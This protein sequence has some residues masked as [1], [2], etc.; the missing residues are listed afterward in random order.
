MEKTT[1]AFLESDLP[2]LDPFIMREDTATGWRGLT[3]H[4]E[5]MEAK[6]PPGR[7]RPIAPTGSVMVMAGGKPV[8]RRAMPPDNAT[9]AP[10]T[11]QTYL[12]HYDRA[13]DLFKQC[14]TL[15]AKAEIDYAA[16]MAVTTRTRFLRALILLTL[17]YWKAGLLDLESRLDLTFPEACKRVEADGV[18]RWRGETLRGKSLILVQDAGFGDTIMGLRYVAELRASFGADVYLLA[19]MAFATLAGRLVPTIAEHGRHF[20]FYCPTLSLMHMMG[21][22]PRTISPKPYLA[23]S[24]DLV[25]RLR[26]L[27]RPKTRR[28]IGIAW[29][30]GNVVPGD[31]HREIP[32]ELLVSHL[33]AL[34]GEDAE[35]FSVQVQEGEI[36][37]NMGVSVLPF[38][39]FDDC[40]AL[41]MVMDEIV[42]V[43]TAAAHLAGAIGHPCISLLLARWHSWRWRDDAPLYEHTRFCRQDAPG[44]WMS[45]LAKLERGR[46][47]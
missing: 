3:L 13:L 46:T 43:D 1:E 24:Q 36:A 45:A 10:G 23:P 11:I 2:D 31:Y 9:C 25:S 26:D 15:E 37:A 16:A 35:L 42:T 20:D 8:G 39:D 44:D 29:S 22:T 27:L 17:G 21:E 28:N 32:L 30:V 18:P 38:R 47:T 7:P 5:M 19:P 41:M 33:T 6:A 34:Y 4:G 12:S 40:A 14:R